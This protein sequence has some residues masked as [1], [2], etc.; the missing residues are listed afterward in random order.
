MKK[1]DIEILFYCSGEKNCGDGMNDFTPFAR[2]S[3]SDRAWFGCKD[4]S[5][6]IISA[7]MQV[8]ANQNNYLFYCFENSGSD[9]FISQ[10]IIE[11]K[12][13]T[14]D[15]V[16]VTADEIK[17]SLASKG[18][19]AIYGIHFNSN[20]EQIKP[21]SKP[22]LNEIALFLAKNPEIKLYVVGHTDS[23]GNEDYNQNLSHKR[24]LSVVKTLIDKHH[25]ASNR[26]QARGVGALVPI[27]TNQAAEGR[28]L[29]RRVE[30]VEM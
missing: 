19:V 9:M 4:S 11:E 13:I 15:L 28:Q 12:N 30:L 3:N 22:V 1:N 27:S 6:A 16:T 2:H 14:T 20:S 5:A 10:T 26:L 21:E 24:G 7:K 8:S 25:I 17:K 29:N 18:K 23:Q